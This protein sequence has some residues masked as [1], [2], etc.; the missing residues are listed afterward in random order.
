MWLESV[1]VRWDPLMA[2][3]GERGKGI[4]AWVWGVWT[5]WI[6]RPRVSREN[7]PVW[8]VWRVKRAVALMVED[9]KSR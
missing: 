8:G 2:C 9:G 4:G 7:G 3:G 1:S 6:V 5:E